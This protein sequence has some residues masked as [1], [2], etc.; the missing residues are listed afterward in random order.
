MSVENARNYRKVNNRIATAG[1]LSEEQ[2]AGL[3]SEGFEA[4]ISLLPPDSPYAVSEEEQIVRRQ[5]IDY[6]CIPVDFA[7]PRPEDFEAFAR[8]MD[9]ARDRKLLVH[10]AANYRVS[11]FYSLYARSR[12]EW[13][14]A[15]ASEFI[16]SVWEPADY[17]GWPDFIRKVEAGLTSA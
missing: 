13:T 7:A 1:S 2:L 6:R 8:A 11:V 10:C 3:G 12:G 4:V 16:G 17:P 9:E 14:A 15:R 5:G